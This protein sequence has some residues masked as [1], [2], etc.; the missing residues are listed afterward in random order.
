M[1]SEIFTF[2][3]FASRTHAHLSRHV[4]SWSC[5]CCMGNDDNML[6]TDQSLLSA[7][8]SRK[9]SGFRPANGAFQRKQTQT[10]SE[11]DNVISHTNIIYVNP[12]CMYLTA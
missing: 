6:P 7:E 2:H 3:N 11:D 10:V 8:N 12:P 5:M 4:P 1:Q 9:C